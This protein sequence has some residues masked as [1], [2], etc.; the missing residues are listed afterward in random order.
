MDFSVIVPMKWKPFLISIFLTIIAASLRVWP[1]YIHESRLVWLTFY[2]AVMIPAI[3]GGFSAGL[4]VLQ[5]GSISRIDGNI[6]QFIITIPA[7]D[8]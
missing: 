8:L 5:N 2:P 4:L 6:A 7:G 1:L 3:C